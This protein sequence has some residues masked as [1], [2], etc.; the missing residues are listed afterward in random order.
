MVEFDQLADIGTASIHATF[1]WGPEKRIGSQENLTSHDPIMED[2]P[3]TVS[4]V[5][6]NQLVFTHPTRKK[7]P[8]FPL[9][10]SGSQRNCNST[11][12]LTSKESSRNPKLKHRMTGLF[13]DPQMQHGTKESEYAP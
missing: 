3:K 1:P 6:T 13:K 2:H 4:G 7:D 10:I 12:L 8:V 11:L 5:T 9:V